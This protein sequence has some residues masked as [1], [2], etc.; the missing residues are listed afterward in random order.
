MQRKSI[1]L[2]RITQAEEKEEEKNGEWGACELAS[3]HSRSYFHFNRHSLCLQH[4][5]H[6]FR[7]FCFPTFDTVVFALFF[8][9]LCINIVHRR[10][11]FDYALLNINLNQ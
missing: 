11:L 6:L 5:L 1:L 9:K 4:K 8:Q 3:L 10:P 2:K 7:R